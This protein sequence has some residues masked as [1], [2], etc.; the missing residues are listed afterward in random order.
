MAKRY[1]DYPIKIQRIHKWDSVINAYVI[2]NSITGEVIAYGKNKKQSDKTIIRKHLAKIKHIDRMT[3]RLKNKSIKD[4]ESKIR[5]FRTVRKYKNFNL[6]RT[7]KIIKGYSAQIIA[8][9]VN[10]DTEED[11]FIRTKAVKVLDG[12]RELSY[13][14]RQLESKIRNT[15]S[16]IEVTSWNFNYYI[17]NDVSRAEIYSEYQTRII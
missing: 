2:R 11:I 12:A 13:L 9:A 4:S 1:K 8:H 14:K 16:N 3:I 6:I 7:N 5:T 17:P 10:K 15:N